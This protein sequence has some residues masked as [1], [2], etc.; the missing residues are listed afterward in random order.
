MLCL[1]E[2]QMDVKA[3]EQWRIERLEKAFRI[4]C[5]ILHLDEAQLRALVHSTDDRNG[6]L[7]VVWNHSNTEAQSIAWSVAWELCGEHPDKTIHRVL[8]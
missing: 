6:T 3:R 4:A 7:T 2:K 1:E 8:S 5:S